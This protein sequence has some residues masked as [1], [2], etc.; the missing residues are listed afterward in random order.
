MPDKEMSPRI[1]LPPGNN[2]GDLP[3]PLFFF[4]TDKITFANI[5]VT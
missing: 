1:A 5:G 3:L 2:D 4:Q